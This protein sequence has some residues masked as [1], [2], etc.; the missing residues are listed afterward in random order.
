M[1]VDK[2]RLTEELLR[3]RRRLASE[4]ELVGVE[5]AIVQRDLPFVRTKIRRLRLAV[6]PQTGGCESDWDSPLRKGLPRHKQ[7]ADADRQGGDEA[8]SPPA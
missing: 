1:N 7:H 8:L 5:I 4:E 2:E 6:S 3:R